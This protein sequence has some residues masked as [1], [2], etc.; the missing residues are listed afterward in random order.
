MK[1]LNRGQPPG[2]RRDDEFALPPTP[3]CGQID[4][5]LGRPISELAADWADHIL[6]CQYCL[7]LWNLSVQAENVTAPAR[8]WQESLERLRRAM[9]WSRLKA[10]LLDKW[11][12]LTDLWG[13]APQQQV[14]LARDSYTMAREAELI[15]DG[16]SP[17]GDEVQKSDIPFDIIGYTAEG[18]A[19]GRAVGELIVARATAETPESGY[20][21]VRGLPAEAA[22]QRLYLMS[23]TCLVTGTESI[24]FSGLLDSLAQQSG[25]P[26]FFS[27][28][29]Q[30]RLEQSIPRSVVVMADAALSDSQG[31]GCW[32]EFVMP[33]RACENFLGKSSRHVL[34][35][36]Q[37]VNAGETADK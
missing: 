31:S 2:A 24:D 5:A 1:H 29:V 13:L 12:E 3:V 6:T 10:G 37:E 23:V 34:F 28:N 21:R 26:D 16:T 22:G 14:A 36:M 9:L 30:L 17:G 25:A 18:V 15:Q 20:L 8:D 33:S 35:F 4:L 7:P 32:T 19:R 11:Q 27:D